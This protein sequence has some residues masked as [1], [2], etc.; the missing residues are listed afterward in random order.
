MAFATSALLA[1][2]AVHVLGE[3]TTL[4]WRVEDAVLN[5]RLVQVRDA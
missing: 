5:L 4:A 2:P 3:Q 1:S